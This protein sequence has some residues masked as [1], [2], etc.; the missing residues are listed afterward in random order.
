MN[1]GFVIPDFRGGG[2]EQVLINIA[3]F[4]AMNND[5]YLFVGSN[6][7]KLQNTV[8]NCVKVVE[9][10]GSSSGLRNLYSLIC[11]VKNYRIGYLCGTLSMAFLVP[12][13]GLFNR[14]LFTVSRVGNTLSSDIK[15]KSIIKSVLFK[16]Y[17][18]T[19]LF[20]DSIVCQ[21]EFMRN[22]LLELLPLLSS[23]KVKVIKNPLNRDK[24]KVIDIKNKSRKY[25]IVSIGRLEHQK[26]YYTSLLVIKRLINSGFD[27]EFLIFG[28]G[29]LKDMLI[30]YVEQLQIQKYVS[31]FGF[32]PNPQNYLVNSDL[33]L[34]TS[35]YEGYSNVI[36]ES[37]C[38]GVPVVATNSPGG[39]SEII[40]D[41]F[42]GFL[43][44]VGDHLDLAD[45]VSLILAES[46]INIQAADV[47]NIKKLHSVDAI[48]QQFL[49][50][51]E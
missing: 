21:S 7:G 6:S 48:S 9:L 5:V 33:L 28:D 15:N 37:L 3:N 16:V 39:N 1:Y 30:K 17:F 50:L 8:S 24:L 19:L 43:S 18:H 11:A 13:I 46:K 42:N 44:P 2:A 40:I 34:L 27:V 23:S 4:L 36:I 20:S 10:S 31:F 38:L 35:L 51:V 14:K 22:D 29:S 41:G 12:L 47:E 25:R 49:D 45:K 32:E 26:D